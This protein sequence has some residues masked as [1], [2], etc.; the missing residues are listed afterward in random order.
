MAKDRTKEKINSICFSMVDKLMH[1]TKTKMKKNG[2]KNEDQK[3]KIY[4]V[5]GYL[6]KMTFDYN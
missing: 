1:Q 4:P 5:C 6:M 3:K 2:N